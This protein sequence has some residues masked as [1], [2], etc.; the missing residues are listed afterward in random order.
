M[1][2]IKPS[3]KDTALALKQKVR[4]AGRSVPRMTLDDLRESRRSLAGLLT[5]D[6]A[7]QHMQDAMLEYYRS[8][9][10]REDI[11]DAPL[12]LRSRPV[13]EI[14]GLL[15]KEVSTWND[16]GYPAHDPRGRLRP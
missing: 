5:P 12:W 6:A 2:A 9:E 7:E 4:A 1:P 10:G 3:H 8:P 13:E 16:S 11:A 15:M 14:V